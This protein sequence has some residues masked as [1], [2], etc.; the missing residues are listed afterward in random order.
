MS[1]TLSYRDDNV[2]S[3][4]GEGLGTC[5]CVVFT[6]SASE[7][8]LSCALDSLLLELRAPSPFC[9]FL[10]LNSLNEGIG[11]WASG[12]LSLLSLL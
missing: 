1:F 3:F 7:V 6:D 12:Y 11:I 9:C 8:F 2:I 4:V 5:A 10:C